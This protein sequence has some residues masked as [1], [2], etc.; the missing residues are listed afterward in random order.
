MPWGLCL[1]VLGSAGLLPALGQPARTRRRNVILFVADGL[2]HGSVNQQETPALWRVRT[3]GVHFENSHAV[4]P[5]LTMANSSVLATGHGL[6]DTGVY[7][8]TLWSG[9]ATFD[10]GNFNLRPGTP[11]PFIG[12]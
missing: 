7:S 2:R 6:G 3:Q 4:F 12:H 1:A 11:V 8:N 5:T 10:S 9:F